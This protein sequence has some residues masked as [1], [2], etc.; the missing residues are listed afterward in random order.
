MEAR[1]LF[2]LR[3]SR[4]LAGERD[5]RGLAALT[6]RRCS[7][8]AAIPQMGALGSL[9]VAAAGAVACFELARRRVATDRGAQP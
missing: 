4:G 2:L 1:D 5:G 6:R 3:E 7:N 9:N 8:L